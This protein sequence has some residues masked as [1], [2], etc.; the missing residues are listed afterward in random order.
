[1]K[2][3]FKFGSYYAILLLIFIP[4]CKLVVEFSQLSVQYYGSNFLLIVIRNCVFANLGGPI[5][6]S[7][8]YD[9]N[10]KYVVIDSTNLFDS[11]L[12]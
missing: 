6:D 11:T 3:I 7:G 9:K 10:Y 4:H 5:I 8:K 12:T 2:K 1:M